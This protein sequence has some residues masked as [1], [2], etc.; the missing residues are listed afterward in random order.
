MG[1]FTHLLAGHDTV[2]CAYYLHDLSAGEGVGLE[3]LHAGKEAVRRKRRPK[4][5]VLG[6][7]EFYLFGHGTSSGYPFLLENANYSIGYGEFNMPSFFV[8][9]RSEALWREGVV[10]LH[11]RFLTW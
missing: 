11:E 6:G 3:A 7:D 8:T 4:L 2:E 9:L 1:S 10:A 5:V